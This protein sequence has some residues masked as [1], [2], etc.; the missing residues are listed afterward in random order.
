MDKL[1]FRTLTLFAALL[2]V[3]GCAA[4]Y[5]RLEPPQIQLADIT[6]QKANF[7]EQHFRIGLRVQNPNARDLV[8]DGIAF[9]LELGGEEFATGTGGAGITIPRNGSAMIEIEAVSTLAGWMKQL[10]QFRQHGTE[11]MHYR[12]SGRV[13]LA[14]PALDLPFARTGEF[15]WPLGGKHL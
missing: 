15:A 4:L 3:G 9:R 7:L 6:L 11:P 2:L 5:P 13:R 8:V 10:E 1:C 14:S 12:L